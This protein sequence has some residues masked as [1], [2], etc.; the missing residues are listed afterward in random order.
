MADRRQASQDLEALVSN[1]SRRRASSMHLLWSWVGAGKT[2]SLLYLKYLTKSSPKLLAVFTEF[3]KTA[4][5]FADVV[6]QLARA[7]PL[8]LIAEQYLEVVTDPRWNDRLRPEPDFQRAA[9]V[10]VE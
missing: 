7:L 3:P 2:H 9:R 5:T 1:L 10:L 8:E 4:R 6:R